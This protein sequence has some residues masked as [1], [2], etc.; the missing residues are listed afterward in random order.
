[1]DDI[2]KIDTK[3]WG[4]WFDKYVLPVFKTD[5]REKYYEFIKKKQ[6]PFYPKFWIAEKFYE[7]I[8]NDN[9]FDEELKLFFAFLYSCGF[10]MEFI[11]TF[12]DWLQMPNWEN[13]NLNE[14]VVNQESI[15]EILKVPNGINLLKNKFRWLPFLIRPEGF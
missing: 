2:E 9:R 10:Y 11:I 15:V 6:P 4:R 7:K 1:M 5:G 14:S 3:E 13:P 12:D 8:K